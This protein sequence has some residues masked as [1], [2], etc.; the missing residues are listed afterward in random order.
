MFLK[1]FEKKEVN[2]GNNLDCRIGT[3]IEVWATRA[4]MG[5]M[6]IM[7]FEFWIRHKL[8][9]CASGGIVP[10]KGLKEKPVLKSSI[11]NKKNTY[12]DK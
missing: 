4:I 2:N 5:A 6:E 3:S 1:E 10:D 8:Q 11:S 12:K 9:A 7:N